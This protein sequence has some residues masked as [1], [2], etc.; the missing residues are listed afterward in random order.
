MGVILVL[1]LQLLTPTGLVIEHTSHVP[2]P[3]MQ[4]CEAA[5]NAAEI[6]EYKGAMVIGAEARCEGGTPT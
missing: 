2:M 5:A 4:V 3:N 6:V 1:V